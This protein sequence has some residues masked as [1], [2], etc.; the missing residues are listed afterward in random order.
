VAA[1]EQRLAPV[2]AVAAG[3]QLHRHVAHVEA[4]ERERVQDFAGGTVVHA[5][6]QRAVLVVHVAGDAAEGRVGIAPAR[7]AVGVVEPAGRAQAE[8]MLLAPHHVQLGQQVQ[9][10]GH[11]VAPVEAVVALVGQ[12]GVADAV[13][14]A[15]RADGVVV[16]DRVVPANAQ[17]R[18]AG[19]DLEGTGVAEAREQHAGGDGGQGGATARCA[20]LRRG[21]GSVH[22]FSSG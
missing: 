9:P 21:M 11:G 5:L 10:L 3:L 17:I 4:G 12:R 16:A 22:S 7:V 2:Q 13:V 18:I 14:A 15:L 8:A 19:V 1:E 20:R 6:H